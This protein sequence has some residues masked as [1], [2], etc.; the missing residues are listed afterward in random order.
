MIENQINNNIWLA[1]FQ[2]QLCAA[3]IEFQISKIW[4]EMFVC[5][6]QTHG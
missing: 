3:Q 5:K 4:I 2:Q 1:R 6:T